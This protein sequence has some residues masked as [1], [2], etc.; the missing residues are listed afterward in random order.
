MRAVPASVAWPV[1]VAS[2]M[3]VMLLALGGKLLNDADTY[4]QIALGDWMIANRAVPHVDVYSWTMAGEPWIS[5]QW[6]AQ[7]IFA[8]V[9]NA[10]GWSGVVAISALAIASAFGLLAYHLMRHLAPMPALV[11]TVAA[12]VLAAPHMLA[13]PH[14]LALPVMVLWVAGL[15]RA[16]DEKRAPSFWLLPLIAL[17]ANLHGGFTF[18][19]FLIAPVA[20]EA[21]I[22]AKAQERMRVVLRWALFGVAA[23]AA[24]CITPYGPESILVTRRILGL[25]P[26]LALIGEWQPENFARLGGLEICLLAAIGFLLYRRI[27]LPPVRILVVL[28]LVHM[29][30]SQSRSGEMLGLVAPLFLAAPLAPQLGGRAAGDAKPLYTAAA[31]ALVLFAA[32]MSVVLPLSLRY[33]PRAEVSPAGAAAAVKASGRTH[34]L[35]S[36][37]FGG[38]L[39]AQGVKPFIDGRTELYG[40]D[41]F[42]RHDAA[43]NLKNVSVFYDLMRARDI[44]VT[45]LAPS[46]PAVGLLDRMPGWT[47][48]YADDTAV[49]H[50]RT[51]AAR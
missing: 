15:V 49:V 18:G 44:D 28:G 19:L 16:A 33:S 2:L 25:G 26:A 45:L 12:F 24:A 1:A 32:V 35:N 22:N 43:V 3:Y 30:L 14:A 51:D 23:L 42:L 48:V 37:D 4:W 6:L 40:A 9:Y 7:V 8:A 21:L 20:L 50:V 17:W 46:T 5:S 13:R 41:F 29:A 27:T 38:Y 47:R 39:I 31:A 10:V 36:Y 34:L 11:L